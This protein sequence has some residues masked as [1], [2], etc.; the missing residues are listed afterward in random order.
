MAAGL[1][2]VAS[3]VGGISEIVAD[4][5]TG[6]LVEPDDAESL[7]AALERLVDDAELRA[8]FGEAGR[9]R[10]AERFSWDRAAAAYRAIFTSRR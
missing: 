8:R 10:A 5:E 2:V 6:L 1:P 4:G 7:A 3:R 9:Q